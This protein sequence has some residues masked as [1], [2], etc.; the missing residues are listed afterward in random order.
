MMIRA[1]DEIYLDSAQYILGHAVDF[2]LMTLDVDADV[3]GDAFSVSSISKQF[4]KG[5]PRYVAGVNGCELARLVLTMTNISFTDAEDVMYLD[6]GPE[7]WA[8]WA[9]AYYQWYSYREFIGI[10]SVVPLSKIIQMYPVFHEMDIMKFVEKMNELMRKSEIETRLKRLRLY[11]GLSQSRLADESGVSIRQIQL[12]EQKQRDINS[13]A[14]STLLKLSKVLHCSI[15]D[16]ME[17]T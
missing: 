8:G 6:K 3:F 1:Y 7:F 10:L 16:L 13:A 11:A 5:N 15:E 12:F 17:Y 14:A 4:A 9:L 2:A